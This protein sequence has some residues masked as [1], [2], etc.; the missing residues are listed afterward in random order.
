MDRESLFEGNTRV[1]RLVA[2]LLVIP[3]EGEPGLTWWLSE[4]KTRQLAIVMEEEHL[5]RGGE[6][7]E[8]EKEKETDRNR[9]TERDRE[10]ER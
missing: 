2:D 7:G 6:R 9:E 1:G 8:R 10:T 5:E 3:K 4:F